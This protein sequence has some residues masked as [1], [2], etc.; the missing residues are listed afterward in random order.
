MDQQRS[1]PLMHTVSS[2]VG[3]KEKTHDIPLCIFPLADLLI[4]PKQRMLSK[5]LYFHMHLKRTIF[6]QSQK[7]IVTSPTPS[8]VQM[9]ERPA[10]DT[11]VS[12][13]QHHCKEVRGGF[14]GYCR[15][16]L[17]GHTRQTCEQCHLRV[18]KCSAI[19]CNCS[20]GCSCAH[21]SNPL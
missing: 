19:R 15:H 9:M 2:L 3:S 11:G 5:W 21:W 6:N 13:P 14:C 12:S 10:K 16:K 1:F 18:F 8:S 7:K 17:K 4:C 20:L